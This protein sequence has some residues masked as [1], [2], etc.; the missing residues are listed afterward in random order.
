VDAVAVLMNRTQQAWTGKKIAGALLMDVKVAFN[1]VSRP[2][3]SRRLREL[4]IE[5]D[6][7]RWTD[8]YVRDRK[9]KLVLEGREGEEHEVETGLPQGSPVAPILFTAYLSGVFDHVESACPGIQGLSFVD[10]VA[11]W[12]EGKRRKQWR[13]NGV[14]F[15]QAKTE[16]MFLSKR[17][18]TPS[19]TVDRR[20]RS[21]L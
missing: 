21:P 20:V 16:A 7:V 2:V 10:D 4:D 8:T 3:L 13:E 17:R 6:L 15:D 19:K 14:T 12:V 18:K 5:P 1:N 11:W 9:A